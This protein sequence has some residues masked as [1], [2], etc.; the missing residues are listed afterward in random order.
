MT[1]VFYQAFDYLLL[2]FGFGFVVF[3]HELGHFLA[4]KYCDVKVD[5]F[6]VGFGP[7]I[8]SWRKGLGFRAGSSTEEYHAKLAANKDAPATDRQIGETEY[9]LN[10]VPL[11]GYVKMLGQ[12][13]LKPG[14]TADDPR[15]YNNKSIGSRMIIVSAGVIMN[16]IL[17]AIGFMTLFLT[18]YPAPPAVVG[19][20]LSES[21]AMKAVNASGVR[22]G[23]QP[24][25][26]IISYDGKS[27]I[28]DFTKIVLN[29]ALTQDGTTIPVV[30]QHT[31]GREETLFITPTHMTA[32]AKGVPS[33]GVMQPAELAAPLPSVMDDQDQSKLALSRL[34]DSLLLKPGDVITQINGKDV[35]S[36]EFWILSDAL[37]QSD[38]KP[39]EIT[40]RSLKGEISHANIHA[41][42]QNPFGD[43]EMNFAGMVPRTIVDGLTEKSTAFNKLLPGD[44]ILSIDDGTDHLPHPSSRQ[45]RETLAAAGEKDEQSHSLSLA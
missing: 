21:P 27:T 11:G 39:I 16:V 1:V 35:K 17:A 28:G 30:I 13:D 3:F 6:A 37:A 26:K 9:R 34:P 18:G 15:A 12:D 10:W 19:G 2:A 40:I 5:Q 7:A 22:V 44:I 31:D 23:L 41:V 42:L 45:V 38:G 24:G 25:D 32:D 20:V 4:A 33:I 43:I 8:F 29:V 36:D 14:V